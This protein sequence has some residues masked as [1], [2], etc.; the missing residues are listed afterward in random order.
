MRGHPAYAL[1]DLVAELSAAFIGTNI[2]LL[3]DHLED[4]AADIG[5]WLKALSNNPSAFLTAASKA[6]AVADWVLR[7]MKMG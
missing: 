6:Q 1:E 4:H 5:E 7:E 3:A 2:G